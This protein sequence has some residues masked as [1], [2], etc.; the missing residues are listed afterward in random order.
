MTITV[1]SRSTRREVRN[2]VLALPAAA[3]LQA[4]PVEVRAVLRDLFREIAADARE[5]ANKCWRTH[6]GPMAL[7]W[8]CVSVYA[9]H[10]GR[11]LK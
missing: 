2:P 3:R 4:Q 6:K 1:N 9:N 5:R 10:I 8:K 7:Y 11:A